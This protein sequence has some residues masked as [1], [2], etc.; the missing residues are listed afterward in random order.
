MT[1]LRIGRARTR[2]S[3][4][5]ASKSVLLTAAL[6]C[7]LIGLWQ[8]GKVRRIPVGQLL[9]SSLCEKRDLGLSG[10]AGN[11]GL[12]LGALDLASEVSGWQYWSHSVQLLGQSLFLSLGVSILGQEL[13]LLGHHGTPQHSQS[14][15]HQTFNTR[16]KPDWFPRG[17]ARRWPTEM[18]V[19]FPHPL[20]PL[21]HSAEVP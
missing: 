21:S 20:P 9:L 12:H 13:C 1:Q 6:T 19:P 3:R 2:T 4:E 11:N 18:W 15:W 17:Q 7:L 10:K 5:E 16:W 14:T 8:A